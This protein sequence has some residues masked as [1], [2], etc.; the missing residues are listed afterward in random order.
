MATTGMPARF[1]ISEVVAGLSRLPGP[2]GPSFAA[3]S[4][5]RRASVLLTSPFGTGTPRRR[6]RTVMPPQGLAPADLDFPV[7]PFQGL[8]PAASVC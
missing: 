2:S 8:A 4:L 1:T 3:A 7:T 6:L 5:L